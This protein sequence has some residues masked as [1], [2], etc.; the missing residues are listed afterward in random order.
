M[1][2]SEGHDSDRSSD[3]SGEPKKRVSVEDTVLGLALI[4]LMLAWG[5]FGEVMLWIAM[6]LGAVG[7]GLKVWRKRQAGADAADKETGSDASRR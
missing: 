7:G 1:S 6:G 4:A 5:G 3:D 2:T